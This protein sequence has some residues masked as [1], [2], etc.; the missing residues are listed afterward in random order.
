MKLSELTVELAQRH[1]RSEPDAALD[2]LYLE[3]AKQYVLDYTGLTAE[4]ADGKEGLTM[5]AL[6]LF[7]ELTDNKGLSTD[8]DKV[9]QVL[10]SFLDLH[11]VNL[12]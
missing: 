11:R 5:A 9:N 7:A 3:Q 12:L 10:A 4:E 8:T 2:S 6:F 1:A